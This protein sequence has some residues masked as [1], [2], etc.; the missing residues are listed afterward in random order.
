M[1]Y[2]LNIQG[3]SKSYDGE[4]FAL[5]DCTFQ[6]E[7]GKICAVVGE[8]G[9]GKSTLLRL[10]AG[11]ERPNSGEIKINDTVVSS[12][13]KVVAPQHRQVGF[14]F[15]N[16]ALFPHL[17]VEKNIAFGLTQNKKERVAELLQLIRME[18]YGD[19]YP[20]QLSGGQQQRVALARTL[21][22]NP[23][24]L[25]LDEPFSNL[26]AHLK[27]ELRRE[28]K[29]IVKKVGT[30]LI[31]ITHD[32]TDALDIADELLF[33][34]AGVIQAHSPIKG[35]SDNIR[36]TEVASIISELKSGAVTLLKQLEG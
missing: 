29:S 24:L 15:Q 9:C 1:E 31:F 30:S 18:G 10:I 20:S 35:L 21:A 14:V 27:T 12:D 5:S 33:L 11:L 16:Y 19:S 4:K 8:S 34:K 26:D 7:R 22:V 2:I 3:L 23:E 28:I 32:I 13:Q 25:L 36:N 6:L 17:T